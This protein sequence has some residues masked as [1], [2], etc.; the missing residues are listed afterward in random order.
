MQ[1]QAHTL[2]ILHKYAEYNQLILM[3]SIITLNEALDTPTF[4]GVNNQNMMCL[5]NQYPDVQDG[6][7]MCLSLH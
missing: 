4:Y 6:E 3:E 1:R 5:R 7:C 2:T